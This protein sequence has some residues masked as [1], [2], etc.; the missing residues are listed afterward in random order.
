MEPPDTQYVLS[1]GLHIAYQAFG[2]GPDVVMIPPLVSNVELSWDH[3]LYR[4]VLEFDAQHLRV[5]MFDKRGIGSSDRFERIPTLE[6]RVDDIVAV[7]DAEGIERAS[8]IGMSE[9]GLMAQLFAA[10]FPERVDKLVL[11]NS[12]PGAGAGPLLEQYREAGDPLFDW[13]EWFGNWKR[14]VETWGTDPSFMID[15]MM[16]SQRD[17]PSFARWVGRL[18]RQTASPADIERQITSVVSLDAMS[19]LKDIKA[20]TLVVHVKGDRVLGVASGRILADHIPGARFMEVEGEDH[21]LWVMPHWRTFVDPQLEFLT[22][23]PPAT[24]THRRFAAVLFTDLVDSTARSAAAG[25]AAWRGTLESHDRICREVVERSAGRLVK[26]T[27]DGLLAVFD[28]PSQAVRAAADMVTKLNAIDL[29]VRCG[30][31][32]GEMEVR[33]DGDITGTAVNL[34]ARVEQAAGVGEVYVSS[35]VRD[36][37]LGGEHRFADRGEHQLKGIEG[38]WKL[39]A[40]EP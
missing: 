30:I 29:G 36:L 10:R 6:E 5:V 2:S 13:S 16:P 19:V 20:P 11:L 37:L 18:Q 27:G 35:T 26:S 34:A 21:F 3:E 24:T 15:W 1:D 9:G 38:S 17:N 39:Y 28:T 8:I 31:H 12:S 23:L 25:D 14:L 7:M 22:G 4:R 32:A 33:D 40:L